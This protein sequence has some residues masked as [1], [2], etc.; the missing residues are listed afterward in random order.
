MVISC[1]AFKFLVESRQKAEEGRRQKAEDFNSKLK[2]QNS[3]L[4]NI[5]PR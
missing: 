3:K 1:Y 5:K 2:T 4:S